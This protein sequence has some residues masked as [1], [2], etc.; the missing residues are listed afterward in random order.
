MLQQGITVAKRQPQILLVVSIGSDD[1]R[2]DSLFLSNFAT[3]RVYDALARVKGVG[4]VTIL[5]ARDYGMRIW[6]DPKKM[7]NLNVTTQDVSDILNEQ[8]TVAP[9]GTVGGEP[10]PPAIFGIEMSIS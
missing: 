7:A 6:L 4:Q 5:G 8:N 2:Y 9:A 1:P 10:A 3:L